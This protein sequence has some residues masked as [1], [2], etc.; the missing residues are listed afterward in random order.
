M[1]DREIK[2]LRFM[3]GYGDQLAADIAP[4]DFC[5]QPVEGMNHPAW[6]FGHLALAA[7]AHAAYVGGTPQLGDWNERFGFG[8]EL[9]IH[10]DEYP[11][12]DELMTA[13]HDANER[14]IVAVAGASAEDLAKPTQGPLV[15]SLPTVG[16]FLTF[17]LTAHVSLHLGQLSA[18]RRAS[19]MPRLF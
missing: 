14:Y 2:T 15:E 12:K 7:D 19:G 16:D 5:R 6:I 3:Q 17:S 13:W 8:S 4:Q 9:L 1:Y 11:S 10:P 18:W